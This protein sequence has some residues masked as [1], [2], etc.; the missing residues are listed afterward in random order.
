[1]G[2]K[3]PRDHVLPRRAGRHRWPQA[4]FGR[5]LGLQRTARKDAGI[6]F[7][8]GVVA[9]AQLSGAGYVRRL[10]RAGMGFG[11]AKVGCGPAR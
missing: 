4:L 5:Y 6:C 3:W 10:F 11:F 8:S 7:R 1:M 2:A 9:L